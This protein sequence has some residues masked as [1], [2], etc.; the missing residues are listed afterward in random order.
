M[1][2][3]KILGGLALALVLLAGLAAYLLLGNLNSL[4][5]NAIEDVG[6]ELTG[7]GVTLEGV[8]ID[9]VAG[10]GELTGLVIGNPPGYKSNFAMRVQK[11][12]IAIDP[13]SLT[14]PVIALNEISIKGARLNAEQKG[15]RT[16]LSELLEHIEG[17]APDSGQQPTET[18]GTADDVRVSLKKF[19]FANA[20]AKVISQVDQPRTVELPDIRRKNIGD[21]KVGLTPQQLGDELLQAVIEEVERA[22]GAYLGDMAREAAK[23][24]VKKELEKA[25]EGKLK[26]LDALLPND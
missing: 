3:V 8:N 6:T 16:N 2:S 7:S 17:S 1:K 12:A 10:R 13:A 20:R 5:E 11:V 9:L 19:V 26:G 21:P 22:V 18:G 25:T 4:V 15:D 23:E 14:G 24:A